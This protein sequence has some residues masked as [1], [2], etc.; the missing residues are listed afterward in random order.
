MR[1]LLIGTT[2]D[3]SNQTGSGVRR[4]GYELYKNLSQIAADEIKIK[5][6]NYNPILFFRDGLTPALYS[7]FEYYGNY[8]II[9]NIEPKPILPYRKGNVLLVTTFHDF[10]PITEPKLTKSDFRSI[11]TLL[12]LLLV[13]KLGIRMGLKSDY[14]ITNSTQTKEEAIRLGFKK[15]NIFVTNLGVDQRFLRSKKTK[16]TDKSNFKVG[17]MGLVGE[18]KNVSFAISAMNR[19]NNSKYIFEIWG[20]PEYNYNKILAAARNKANIYFMGFAPEDKI[21][22][23]YDSFDVFVHPT[24]YEGFGL[25]ILE[26]QARGL[27]VI[28]YKYGKIPKEVRKYCFEAESPEHMAQIIENIKENGYNEKSRNKATTYAR[29]FTW[30]KTA[31][32]T[33]RAYETIIKRG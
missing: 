31:K 2:N 3:F 25:P 32:E 6:S 1:V 22:S 12:G 30:K 9:H 29:S 20:K 27:P 8:D 5:C 10:R 16:K 7:L 28:I 19:L 14:I 13:L 24:L 18:N 23:I 33:L 17:Y 26:A 4:Y 15:S 11:Q 21:V